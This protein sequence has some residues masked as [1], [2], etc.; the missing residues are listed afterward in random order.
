MS[1]KIKKAKVSVDLVSLNSFE[2]FYANKAE[3]L[4]I[5]ALPM[6]KLFV[7]M[8]PIE[9]RHHVIMF[10]NKELGWNLG[11][12]ILYKKKIGT[13][14]QGGNL[15]IGTCSVETCKFRIVFQHTQK[16]QGFTVRP[17]QSNLIHKCYSE[18]GE[19][20]PCGCTIHV[21]DQVIRLTCHSIMPYYMPYY[22]CI[23][24]KYHAILSCHTICH[25]TF[26]IL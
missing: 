9:K 16:S 20:S 2:V 5:N 3:E 18:D 10:L 7:Q 26:V 11:K 24:V 12:N 15:V 17:Q 8:P 22:F 1:T 4:A 19:E 13:E 23:F 21:A 25:T 6:M 14:C